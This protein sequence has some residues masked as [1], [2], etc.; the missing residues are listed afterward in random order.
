MCN[1]S[2]YSNIIDLYIVYIIIYNKQ[3]VFAMVS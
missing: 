1:I 2:V 3:G